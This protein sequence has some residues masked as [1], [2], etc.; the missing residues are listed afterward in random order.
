M[1]T[2]VAQRIARWASKSKV[3]G[4]IPTRG[5]LIDHTSV[6]RF[7][8]HF[9]G[10]ANQKRDKAVQRRSIQPLQSNPLL[11]GYVASFFV[12]QASLPSFP[13]ICNVI[14]KRRILGS[15][16]KLQV[17]VFLGTLAQLLAS[18]TPLLHVVMEYV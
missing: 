17:V 1:P 4:S 13:P 10:G 6:Q 7:S 12:G 3:V 2:P 5:D 14:T 16:L 9:H 15:I 18:F 11:Y 8:E